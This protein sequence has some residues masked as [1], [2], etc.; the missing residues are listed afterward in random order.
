M[1]DRKRLLTILI[2]CGLGS[3]CL[4]GQLL[5]DPDYS[6]LDAMRQIRQA[7]QRLAH[8]DRSQLSTSQA[9]ELRRQANAEPWHLHSHGSA[10][11]YLYFIGNN[12]FMKALKMLI[13]PLVI[14]SVIVGVTS[15]G[16]FSR[17]GRI[18]LKTLVYYFAT[19][20]V[21]VSLGLIVVNLVRPGDRIS[22]SQRAEAPEEYR[23]TGK[24][25]TVEA[26]V[27]P[28]LGGAL[29]NIVDQMI[30]ANVMAAA[31][32]GKP[33]PVICFSLLFGVLLTM[34][35]PQGRVVAQ[36]FEAI[37]AVMMR[38][39][40]L[41]LW[42]APVGVGCLVAWTLARIG[43]KVFATA[44]GTYMLTVLGGL[45]IHAIVVLPLLLWIFARTHPLVF[46]G[47]MRQALVTAFGTASSSATLPITIRCAEEAG[48]SKK[49]AGFVLPLGATINMDG[50]ALYEAVAVAFL[51]Q[52]WG[53][54]LGLQQ[55]II[56]AL[57][58]TLA[59]VGAAGIPEAGLVTMAIVV[60]AVNQSVLG[61][62]PTT[63]TIPL[64][65]IGLIIGVDRVLD[66]CRTAINVWGDAVGANIISRTEPDGPK[67][68]T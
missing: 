60:A 10:L 51:A 45:A 26:N 52:A 24:Q 17:L 11:K 43:L 35:S 55:N 39:V 33:L 46:F 67:I 6:Q 19:M 15:V 32:Q 63:R 65:A 31:A 16:D 8:A 42:M 27:P 44:I 29:L 40:G 22:A 2:L 21:A 47:Q 18:G 38:M 5:Y 58:A 66:M 1:R 23:Q 57:T 68:G 3:G 56:I 13:I 61:P 14:S 28:G 9:I 64:A 25:E 36:F 62:D 59:A 30:P 41:I 49:A 48:V 12:I 53:V 54:E 20:F 7:K 50:T 4:V 37:F 34:I